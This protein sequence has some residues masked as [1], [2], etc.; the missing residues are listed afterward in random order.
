MY[1]ILN[2]NSGQP[3]YEQIKEHIKQDIYSGRLKHED[4]L[5]SVRQLAKD[6]NISMIT[7]KRAYMELEYEGLIYTVAGKG[8][9]VNASDVVKMISDR[10][11]SL[12]SDFVQRVKGL[13][14]AG[15]EKEKVTGVIDS[16]YLRMESDKHE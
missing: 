6:L 1:F 14:E 12:L 11:D 9:F 16:I 10:N 4:I 15:I 13:K 5:P 2:Y 7:T 8:T 3:M